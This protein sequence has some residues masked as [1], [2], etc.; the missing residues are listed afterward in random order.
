M[1]ANRYKCGQ[2]STFVYTYLST[3]V[4]FSNMKKTALL[5]L[6]CALSV[7]TIAQ[8]AGKLPKFR[9]TT[10]FLTT[11]YELGDKDATDKE[12]QLHFQKTSPEAYYQWRR[13]ESAT[14]TTTVLMWC[15]V[16]ASVV[17]LVAPSDEGKA[18]GWFTAAGIYT[19]ALVASLSAGR[20]KEQARDIYNRAAGY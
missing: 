19:G 15:G 8:E 6:F 3:T 13:G 20:R 10:G 11:K 2:F 4:K 5:L 1:Q 18:A 7:A 14:K 9:I 17:G 12:I 16:A